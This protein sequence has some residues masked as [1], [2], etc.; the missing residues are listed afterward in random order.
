MGPLSSNAGEARRAPG[1][2]SEE[3]RAPFPF[4]VG[5]GRSGTTLLRAIFDSHPE[6]AVTHES[7]FIP[8]LG[9]NRRRYERAGGFDADR[10]VEDLWVAASRR[11]SMWGLSRDQVATAVAAAE[12]TSYADAVRSLFAAYAASQGKPRYADKT[13]RYVRHMPALAR[14]FPEARFVHI[15]RD[16]RDVALSML[17]VAFGPASIDD[18]ARFWRRQV[19]RGRQDGARLG[20][21]R[22]VEVRYEELVA[23]TEPQIRRICSFLDLAFNPAMLQY[24]ERAGEVVA[25]AGRPGQHDRIFLPPT[26]GLR[27]WRT[28]MAP[29]DQARFDAVAG[30][31]LAVLGYPRLNPVAGWRLRTWAAV[32]GS[33][34]FRARPRARRIA[35]RIGRWVGSR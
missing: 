13:P 15:I 1:A 7:D 24:F 30:P 31:L 6:L 32:R 35:R 23:E 2:G 18:A 16:G 8:A 10:F 3:V 26:K 33:P 29:S 14:M 9:A 17:E 25:R 12:P 28:E 11:L 5:C 20:G 19:Q 21:G 4:F 22:Y 27:D 34:L